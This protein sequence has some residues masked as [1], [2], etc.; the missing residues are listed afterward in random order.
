[1][2]EQPKH[3]AKL[4]SAPTESE[5]SIL[6]AALQENGIQASS[7]EYS[8]GLRAGA[9]N[10]VGVLVAEDDLEKAKEVLEQVKSENDHIDW[11]QVDVGEPED[12]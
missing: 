7:E 3:T 12:E 2:S 10:W 6:I 4:T 5:A 8:S 1:M 9:W 11:S